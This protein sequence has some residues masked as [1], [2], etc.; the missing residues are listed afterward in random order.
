MKVANPVEQHALLVGSTVQIALTL[1]L[2]AHDTALAM[3]RD[4]WD[5][6][7]E[8]QALQAAGLNNNDLRTLICGGL[9][10]HLVECTQF[11]AM[12]R[13]FRRPRGMRLQVESCFVLS[14]LGISVARGLVSGGRPSVPF[15]EAAVTPIWDTNRRELHVGDILVK[16]F[17]QPAPNQE[18]ILAAFQEDGWPPRIDNPIAGAGDVE[19]Q[20]RLHNAVKKLNHQINTVLHFSSD[21]RGD[22]VIWAMRQSTVP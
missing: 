12:H 16:R 22:G 8:I 7:M 2:Q 20:D 21:G 3:E 5:F 4:Q 6:A 19:S 11:R 9:A 14:D 10:K 18:T 1:M 13:R 17:R 15:V